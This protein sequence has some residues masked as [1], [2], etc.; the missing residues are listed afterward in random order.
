ML[1]T[2]KVVYEK[3]TDLAAVVALADEHAAGPD[4]DD[5]TRAKTAFF[6]EIQ[7]RLREWAL[8]R[9]AAGS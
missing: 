6:N 4:Y 2:A 8:V 5:Y 9:R 1:R 7:P 3:P